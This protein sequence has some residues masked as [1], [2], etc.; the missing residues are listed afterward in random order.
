M[1]D[2]ANPIRKKVAT[3]AIPVL[4]LACGYVIYTNIFARTSPQSTSKSQKPATTASPAG[5]AKQGNSPAQKNARQKTSTW[6]T[7]TL[8]EIIGHSPFDPLLNSR[9]SNAVRSSRP[10]DFSIQSIPQSITTS[11]SSTPT[12]FN[13]SPGHL[14]RTSASNQSGRSKGGAPGKAAPSQL[15]GGL[16]AVFKSENGISA[17]VDSKVVR[18][19]DSINGVKIIAITPSAIFLEDN[20][21]IQTGQGKK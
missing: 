19:G 15:G 13:A 7:Y 18:P 8:D 1:S 2:Q 20:R 16:Q 4:A 10:Q 12:S 5:V 9:S 3:L 6:P 11:T 14:S 21:T 17:L